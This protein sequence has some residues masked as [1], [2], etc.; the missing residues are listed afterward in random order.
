MKIHLLSDLHLEFGKMPRSYAAPECDVVVLAG[1][2]A[3]GVVGV[4]WAAETFKVPVVYVPGNHEYYGK[5]IYAEHLQRLRD[6]ASGTNVTVLNNDSITIGDVT[7]LGATLWT[8]HDLYGAAP[9]S[10]RVAQEKMYDYKTICI[11]ERTLLTAEDT[12]LL[13][14]ESRYFLSEALRQP[15]RKV[16]ITHHAPSEMSCLPKYKGDTL[17]PGFASRLENLICDTSPLLWV[18]GHMHNSSD[19]TICDTRVVCNPR[20]YVGH[21]LNADFNPTFVVEI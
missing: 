19:Y 17:T 4:M 3:T 5:R 9:L 8:D 11:S 7:F 2:I 15:G 21:E 12:E 10:R 14:K 16:V 13:H 18:H 20:G 6:K 1:D